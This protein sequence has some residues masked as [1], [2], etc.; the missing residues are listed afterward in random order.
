MSKYN[1]LFEDEN[2]IFNGTPVSKY[3]GM[4]SQTDEEILHEEFDTIVGRIAVMEE[5]LAKYYEIE[6]L[7]KAIEHFTLEHPQR[8]EELKK[9]VYME[10]AGKLV[11][12][13]AN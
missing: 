4:V 2:D 1:A 11:Y 6:L 7:D 3:W 12:R 13:A 9:S 10:L 5:M 8:V